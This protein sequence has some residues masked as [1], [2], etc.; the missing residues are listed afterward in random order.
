MSKNVFAIRKEERLV[1]LLALVL[2]VV[3]NGLMIY[4]YYGLFT[5]GGNLGFWS[6]FHDHFCVSGFDVLG[7]LT[8]SRWK[9]FYSLYRH[10]L[11][12]LLLYPLYMLNHWLMGVYGFNFAVFIVGGLMLVCAVYSFLFMHRI[13]REIIGLGRGD[14]LMLTLMTFS[15]A[16]I[17]LSTMVPDHFGLSLFLLTLTL[18]LTG[19]SFGSNG[20]PAWKAGLLFLLTTG[21]T[22]TNG[23]KTVLAAWLSCGRK[24]F[25]WKYILVAFVLPALLLAGAYV[26]QY[27]EYVVPDQIAQ[28]INLNLKKEKDKKFAEK[29][30]KHNAWKEKQNGKPLVDNPLFEWTST[31]APRWQSCVEN[32]FGESIVLHQDYL[33]RDMNVDRPVIVPYRWTVQYVFEALLVALFVWGAWCGRRERLM[34]LCLA[35]LAFDLLLHV[36]LAFGLTEVYIMGAHWL[37]VIPIALAYLLKSLETNKQPLLRLLLWAM[38]ACLWVYNGWLVAGYMLQRSYW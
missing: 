37:F 2:F 27:N 16:Y 33:L 7:Y 25:R 35:C 32:L 17:M 19:K 36:V 10:P 13:F 31:S 38:T 9:V 4:K 24:V 20:L 26:Y 21:V 12:S 30:E 3:L 11:L 15:F 6:L 1:A 23:V 8:V 5:R 34:Q 22:T 29:I 28:D 18:Y 14:A